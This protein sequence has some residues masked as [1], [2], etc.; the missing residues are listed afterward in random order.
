MEQNQEGRIWDYIDGLGD[1][2]ESESVR[3]LISEEP[4][5]RRKYEE[6]LEL[7]QS[8]QEMSL[9]VPSLRFAKNVME[10]IAQNQVG[11]ATISY[12]NKRIIWGIGGFF[13]ILILGFLVYGFAQ[14]NWSANGNSKAVSFFKSNSIPWNKIFNNTYGNIF[15]M[16]N[17]V[18]GLMLLDMFLRRK[19]KRTEA[20]EA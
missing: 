5:W 2:V 7:H 11:P 13:G 16:I 12:I 18:L 14:V 9:E 1:P 10:E 6:L 17:V 3:L 19:M 4:D 8:F 20:K 15:M